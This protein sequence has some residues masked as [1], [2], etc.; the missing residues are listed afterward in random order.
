[1]KFSSAIVLLVSTVAALIGSGL[2]NALPP[3]FDRFGQPN[4]TDGIYGQGLGGFGGL[5]KRSCEE[6]VGGALG[7]R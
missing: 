7:G 2:A 1:M 4:R 6:G 3:G 5:A